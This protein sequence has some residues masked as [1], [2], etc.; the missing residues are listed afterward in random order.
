[1]TE[2]LRSRTLQALSWSFL[3]AV[4]VQCVRFLF[5]IVLARILY[6]EQFGLIGMLMIFM[7]VAETVSECGYGVALIQ[8]K[9]V[10]QTDL[11]S[12]FYFNI[13]V[14]LSLTG[15][16]YL[17]APWISAFYNEPILTS[18]MRAMS[19][20]I[21]INSFSTIHFSIVHRQ[22]SFKTLA[23]IGLINAAV[24]GIIGVALALYGFG[25]WSL[26][27]QQI[28]YAVTRTIL[29]W[30][31]ISWRPS[32]IFSFE[33]LRQMYGFGSRM[34][35]SG[36]LEQIFSNIY[37]VVIG[38][39]FS[40]TDLGYFTRAKTFQEIPTN[41][42]SGLV[43]R[44]TFPVFSK[45]QDDPARLKRG[46]KK[47]LTILALVN[48]PVMIGLAIIAKPLVLVLITE[49]WADCIP[50]LQLLCFNGLLYPVHLINL[51]LLMALGRSDLFLRL[52]I[53]KKVLIIISIAIT[54]RWGISGMIYGMICLSILCYYL[55]SYY[56][57]ILID[58]SIREQ[59]GDMMP[60]L[61]MSGLM[62]I[63]VYAV[64]SLPFPN[65]GSMLLA[66]LMTGIVFYVFLCRI[67]RLTA[68]MELWEMG[69]NKLVIMRSGAA[70]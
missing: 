65:D 1:M 9:E 13:V 27:A 23:I 62:G 68:F 22:L 32:R 55:N 48:I 15:A 29:L 51:H 47:G 40:A 24:S 12:I 57:G 36:L 59:L 43:G 58:Y 67:F 25:V 18:L 64:G 10:T 37:L 45:I 31:M 26:I 66:E 3:E 42:L 21:T 8:K 35:A 20:V 50:Y 34:M 63:A 19:L 6:P 17:A 2:S 60:Y 4:G 7:A 28:S 38:K 70:G 16:L 11:C 39:L 49:K 30:M 53:V 44:V 14:A 61:T 46:M 56:T 33:S 69:R 54:W 41:T 5:G 52:E